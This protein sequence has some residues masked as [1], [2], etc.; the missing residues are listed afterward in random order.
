MEVL[1]LVPVDP[2]AAPVAIVLTSFPGLLVRAGRTSST[3]IPSC[4]CDA[5]DETLDDGAVVLADHVEGIVTCGFTERVV[6]NRGWW[7]ELHD[8]GPHGS[9]SGRTLLHGVRVSE[10]RILLPGPGISWAPWT[11]RAPVRP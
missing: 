1:N 7:H 4:G 3:P 2:A 6:R 11:H 10:L 5:C 9:S 8:P